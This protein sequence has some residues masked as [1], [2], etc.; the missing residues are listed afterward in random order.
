MNYK[1]RLTGSEG[2]KK[3]PITFAKEFKALGLKPYANNS[4]FQNSITK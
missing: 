2:E 1:G 4:Y 3:Q